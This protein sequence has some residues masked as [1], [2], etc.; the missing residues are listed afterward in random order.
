MK[1]LS[2][3]RISRKLSPGVQPIHAESC[4]NCWGIQQWRDQYFPGSYRSNQGFIRKFVR[5]YLDG[6]HKKLQP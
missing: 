3:F 6:I 2:L 1:I 4:P 5:T